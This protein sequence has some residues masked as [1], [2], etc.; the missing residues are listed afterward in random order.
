VGVTCECVF[1][2]LERLAIFI[3][4][5]RFH[6]TRPVAWAVQAPL[7]DHPLENKGRWHRFGVESKRRLCEAL[8]KLVER[9]KCVDSLG[10][11]QCQCHE[12]GVDALVQED[13]AMVVI[14][15]RFCA[16]ASCTPHLCKCWMV[17]CHAKIE[18]TFVLM[19]TLVQAAARAKSG[20]MKLW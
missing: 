18:E 7:A 5:Q 20:T 8:A 9:L 16:S 14:G 19:C 15:Q 4:K 17:R 10:L 12:R 6:Q 3:E 11:C 2:L 13:I 1:H